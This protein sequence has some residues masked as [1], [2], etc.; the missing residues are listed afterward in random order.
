MPGESDTKT[1]RQQHAEPKQAQQP[2]QNALNDDQRR[3]RNLGRAEMHHAMLRQIIRDR[4]VEESDAV[5]REVESAIP[6][7]EHRFTRAEAGVLQGEERKIDNDLK[8]ISEYIKQSDT[9]A[10]ALW[11]ARA[12]ALVLVG[13]LAV[14]WVLNEVNDILLAASAAGLIINVY[15]NRGRESRTAHK[16]GHKAKR[17]LYKAYGVVESIFVIHR[18]GHTTRNGEHAHHAHTAE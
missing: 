1:R 2:D 16:E 4:P 6:R 3:D 18:N 15:R 5:L 11:M 14:D 12:A 9:I 17:M 13:K 10:N 8:K 7:A